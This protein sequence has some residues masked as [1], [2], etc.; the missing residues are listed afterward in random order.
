[1]SDGHI[2]D[3]ERAWDKKC[4]AEEKRAEQIKA[5]VKEAIRAND[6]N[7]EILT[8]SELTDES[9]WSH[10]RNALC[11]YADGKLSIP[12]KAYIADKIL[13]SALKYV[14]EIVESKLD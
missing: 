9:N 10:F 8:E 13:G 12:E 4:E 7:V 1:M 2:I 6:Y 3:A 11:L 5:L 14:T